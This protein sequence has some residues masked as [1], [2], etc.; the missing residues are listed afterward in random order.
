MALVVTKITDTDIISQI[1]L[2][3]PLFKL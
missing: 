3:C 1:S 2:M